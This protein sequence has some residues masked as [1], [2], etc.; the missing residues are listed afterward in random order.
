MKLWDLEIEALPNFHPVMMQVTHDYNILYLVCNVFFDAD[1][2]AIQETILVGRNS[3]QLVKT[4]QQDPG[5][6][7]DLFVHFQSLCGKH[8]VH[9]YLFFLAAHETYCGPNSLDK[10]L[11]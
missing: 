3:F 10:Y 1:W 4:L 5:A 9:E 11:C 2:N 8:E 6:A 7:V